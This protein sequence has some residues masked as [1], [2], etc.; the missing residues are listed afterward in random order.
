MKHNINNS[1]IVA[2]TIIWTF[3]F[4][5]LV[6]FNVQLGKLSLAIEEI[7][8]SL[9]NITEE[10]N[11]EISAGFSSYIVT[12]AHQ[13]SLAQDTSCIKND[14]ETVS[15]PIEEVVEEVIEYIPV[16]S[17]AYYNAYN[18]TC[19]DG[20]WPYVGVVA[21][22]IEWLGKSVD[23]YDEDYNFMGSYTFHDTGYGRSTG[24]GE[25]VILK[26]KNIG[27]IEAGL[28]IDIFMNTY[29]ECVQYGRR[30]IYMVWK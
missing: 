19:A 17:T 25:S 11:D 5:A 10:P 12:T 14:V 7:N 16:E 6:V 23:L 1:M 24:Y 30:N 13:A 8:H 15:E 26:G 4:G 3:I 21:G 9:N 29:E 27:D 28:T 18:R 20:T 22:K 2:L